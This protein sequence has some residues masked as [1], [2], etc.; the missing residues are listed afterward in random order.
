MS[1]AAGGPQVVALG[2]GHGLAATI[3]A[4]RC[5]AS[6]T[7]AVASPSTLILGAANRDVDGISTFTPLRVN[8]QNGSSAW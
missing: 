3:R 2:G 1:H 6:R 5:Y 7:T 8:V 4:A